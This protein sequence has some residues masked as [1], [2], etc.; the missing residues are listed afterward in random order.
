MNLH[1]FLLF[2]NCVLT[3]L[4]AAAIVIGILRREYLPMIRYLE[5]KGPNPSGTVEGENTPRQD[6]SEEGE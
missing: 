1:V 6:S 4:L 3:M 5:G 2:F